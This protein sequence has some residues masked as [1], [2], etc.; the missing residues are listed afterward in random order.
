MIKISTMFANLL[1]TK[2]NIKMNIK[3][4]IPEHTIQE[5]SINCGVLI[6]WYGERLISN[7][8]I[9]G[10]I[11]LIEQR[12]AIYNRI[13]GNCLQEANAN[14]THYNKDTCRI[15]RLNDGDDKVVCM[16]CE[17]SYHNQCISLFTEMKCKLD[18][19]FYCPPK[20]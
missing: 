8:D 16:R 1:E 18:G 15:C 13:V 12:R 17:Q 5:D 6:C 19:G 7:S 3:W 20:K 4:I 10:P 14:S 11:D 2:L 9:T